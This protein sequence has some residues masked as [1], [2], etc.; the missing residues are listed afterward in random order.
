MKYLGIKFCA[1]IKYQKLIYYSIA[2]QDTVQSL[3]CLLVLLSPPISS[4]EASG[5]P[6]TTTK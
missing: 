2:E 5:N 4:I 3:Q 6:N 1:V